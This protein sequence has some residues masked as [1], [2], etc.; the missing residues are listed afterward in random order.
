[1]PFHEPHASY[2]YL[3]TLANEHPGSTVVCADDGEK[4][5]SW[6]ERSTSVHS[7]L[8]AAVLRHDPR[9]SL[10]GCGTTTFAE[11]V[12]NTL[13]LGKIYHPGRVVPRDDRVALPPDRLAR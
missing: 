13:P 5:G 12:D 10:T 1:M 6:P 2:E 8:A 9:Q 3:K 11:A 4:F 7:R